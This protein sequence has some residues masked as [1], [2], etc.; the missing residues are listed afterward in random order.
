MAEPKRL[1][2]STSDKM[3]CGVAAGLAD[4]LGVDPVLIRL[5]FVLVAL[6]GHGAGLLLYIVLCIV[7]PEEG[8]PQAAPTAASSR[9]NGQQ[10]FEPLGSRE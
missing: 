4:Y 6:A 2:R 10:E 5:A 7:M 8:A 3:V 1:T 9:S